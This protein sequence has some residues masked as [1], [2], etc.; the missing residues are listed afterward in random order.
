VG[1][2][3]AETG[4]SLLF[5]RSVLADLEGVAFGFLALFIQ[6]RELKTATLDGYAIIVGHGQSLCWV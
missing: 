2:L 5:T 3:A 1:S 6:D 4:A